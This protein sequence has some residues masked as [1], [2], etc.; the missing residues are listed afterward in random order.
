MTVSPPSN[1]IVP[2]ND[3]EVQELASRVLRGEVALGLAEWLATPYAVRLLNAS[4]KDGGPATQLLATHVT[5][6]LVKMSLVGLKP[7]IKHA[8]NLSFTGTRNTLK[9]ISE[10]GNGSCGLLELTAS[11]GGATELTELLTPI[12]SS[13]VGINVLVTDPLGPRVAE[14]VVS[15][16]GDGITAEFNHSH[17]S[18]TEVIKGYS[19]IVLEG[20]VPYELVRRV[21]TFSMRVLI[22][23]S[24]GNLTVEI[25]GEKVSV[26][27]NAL[28]IVKESVGA[29][30]VEVVFKGF[31]TFPSGVEAPEYLVRVKVSLR[32]PL[33]KGGDVLM[34]LR[35]VGEG[36]AYL[37]G[38]GVVVVTGMVIKSLEATVWFNDVRR[39]YVVEGGTPGQVNITNVSVLP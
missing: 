6:S 14:G 11:G 31:K 30:H 7:P 23:R 26:F 27:P 18:G 17:V 16:R 9:L 13:S 12:N 29:T 24:S 38:K 2:R 15:V 20:G 34:V 19:K 4:I 25:N 21:G 1:I 32:I 22:N 8:Y 3:L 35:L 28:S 37:I 39:C 10:G 5:L 36:R 33:V